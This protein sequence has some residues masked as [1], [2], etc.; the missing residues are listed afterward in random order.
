M[1]REELY[2]EAGQLIAS[3]PGRFAGMRPVEALHKAALLVA[4]ERD[5]SFALAGTLKD[6][7]RYLE[8]PPA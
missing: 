1:T 4:F 5:V 7:R 2:A 6:A 8:K 3:A